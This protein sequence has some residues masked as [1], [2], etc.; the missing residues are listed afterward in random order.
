MVDMGRGC[1]WCGMRLK[2]SSPSMKVGFAPLKM[3]G[4]IDQP[5]DGQTT[6]QDQCWLP[7]VKKNETT[8]QDCVNSWDVLIKIHFLI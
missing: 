6:G 5:F 4:R 7:V 1:A 8:L 2:E 3:T